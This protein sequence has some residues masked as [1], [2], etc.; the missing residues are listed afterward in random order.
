MAV[1]FVAYIDESGDPG[2]RNIK[3]RVENGA[4]EWLLLGCTLF[5][6]EQDKL[7]LPWVRELIGQFKNHQTRDIHFSKL[8]DAKKA[9]SCRLL[10]QKPCRAFVVASNKNNIE[11]YDNPNIRDGNRNW[12]YWWMTRLLLERVTQF[13]AS[14]VP[15]GESGQH[16]VR[17][18][19]SRRGGMRYADLESYLSKIYWQSRAGRLVL[20]GGD[21]D[22]SVID[23]DQLLVLDAV[24]RAGLQLADIV[25]GAFFTALERNRPGEANPVYAKALRPIMAKDNYD[26]RLGFSLKTMPDL[27]TMDLHPSQK[28]VFESYGY[29]PDGW[30]R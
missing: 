15:Q 7:C 5:R 10:A 16:K 30:K 6:I 22:W 11:G 21:L 12:Y 4:S 26:R 25:A 17:L 2:L 9:V 27:H 24:S 19:F 13:C 3:P 23:F 28:S 14:Q 1:S 8:N 18:V 29:N 20:S